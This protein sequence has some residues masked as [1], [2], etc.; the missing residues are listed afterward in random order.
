M[1]IEATRCRRDSSIWRRSCR[2]ASI[3]CYYLLTDQHTYQVRFKGDWKKDSALAK[4]YGFLVANVTDSFWVY[5]SIRLVF[6]FY[7]AAVVN[8]FPG[9]VGC[10]MLS[11]FLFMEMIVVTC[12]QPHRDNWQNRVQPVTFLLNFLSSLGVTVSVVLPAIPDIELPEWLL[13][14]M[15]MFMLV[16][17]TSLQLCLSLIESLSV[18]I[19][20][21]LGPMSAPA[22]QFAGFMRARFERI[23]LTRSS[24]RVGASLSSMKSVNKAPVVILEVKSAGQEKSKEMEAM[25]EGVEVDGDI[26]VA[27]GERGMSTADAQSNAACN[28]AAVT[29]KSHEPKE[30]VL[31][32]SS[33]VRMLHGN[34]LTLTAP[35]QTMDRESA[36]RHSAVACKAASIICNT[37]EGSEGDVEKKVAT[38]TQVDKSCRLLE[39]VRRLNESGVT[40]TGGGGGEGY[41]GVQQPSWPRLPR[42]SGLQAPLISRFIGPS[43]DDDRQRVFGLAMPVLPASEQRQMM[44]ERP[45]FPYVSVVPVAPKLE[46]PKG[47]LP[48]P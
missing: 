16:T 31:F 35:V 40:N 6:K 32:A 1:P 8:L 43:D 27:N 15:L 11:G 42:L 28:S 26:R 41:N 4:W 34:D 44:P 46:V 13:D 48:L 36:L 10:A 24:K 22:G 2:D 45:E 12:K 30:T 7:T 21:L 38:K 23:G 17:A 37:S 20:G 39:V 47:G 33:G 18:G 5:F 9:A 25:E 14:P 3:N 19:C 29:I